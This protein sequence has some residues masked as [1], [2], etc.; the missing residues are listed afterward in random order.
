MVVQSDT[1]TVNSTQGRTQYIKVCVLNVLFKERRRHT[2]S[3][4]PVFISERRNR[5]EPGVVLLRANVVGDDA[6]TFRPKLLVS[7][8][9]LFYNFY[10]CINPTGFVGNANSGSG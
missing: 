5:L 3:Q 4:A 6:L 7:F 1:L 9:H 2:Q 8:V 10:L